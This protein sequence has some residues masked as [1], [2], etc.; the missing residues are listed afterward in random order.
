LP[1]AVAV[2]TGYLVRVQVVEVVLEAIGAGLLQYQ[3][4][5][6]PLRLVVE[7]ALDLL[8]AIHQDFQ[9][10]QPVVA[11]EDLVIVT[12]VQE[13][14]AGVLAME[15]MLE[16]VLLVKEMMETKDFLVGEVDLEE[17]G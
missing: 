9:L 2:E 1:V 15:R 6:T 11:M 12:V 5:H 4:L 16:A 3:L 17:A 13:V 14:L 8:E 7:A 10:L